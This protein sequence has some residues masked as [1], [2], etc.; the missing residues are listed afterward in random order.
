MAGGRGHGRGP[1]NPVTGFGLGASGQGSARAATERH[2]G[3]RTL[4][5][6]KTSP[7]MILASFW[8]GSYVA[9]WLDARGRRPRSNAN[10]VSAYSRSLLFSFAYAAS[11]SVSSLSSISTFVA[12]IL[13]ASH[14]ACASAVRLTLYAFFMSARAS[15]ILSVRSASRDVC[16]CA[17]TVSL[18]CIRLRT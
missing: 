13:K 8:N 2:A 3:P 9:I 10:E 15:M 16:V 4:A 1:P 17:C 6:A 12:S 5:N 11:L 14:S 18:V 7:G